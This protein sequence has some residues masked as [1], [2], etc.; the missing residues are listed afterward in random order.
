MKKF[1]VPALASLMMLGASLAYA[2]NI[3]G[4]IK[5]I[6]TTKKE[7]VLDN[8]QTYQLQQNV[9]TT[10]LKAGDKVTMT[11]Q[12]QNGKTMVSKVAKS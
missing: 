2:A 3:S 8:G 11:T 12:V 1:A 6:D 4:T 9:S 5:S 10:N 7:I